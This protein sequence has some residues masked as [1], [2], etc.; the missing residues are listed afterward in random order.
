M[1]TKIMSLSKVVL[2]EVLVLALLLSHAGTFTA[3]ETQKLLKDTPFEEVVAKAKA[4]DADAQFYLAKGHASS[5]TGVP[6]N[7]QESHK[8]YIAAA[9]NN[10][11]EA[12]FY[13]GRHYY[14]E[15]KSTRGNASKDKAKR[16]QVAPIALNWLNKAANQS[17]FPAWV[18][19]G[20]AFEDGTVFAKDPVE[21]YKWY[22]LA[23]EKGN[24]SIIAPVTQRN[25][26]SLKLTPAQIE[27]AKR[28]ALDFWET[29]G[30]EKKPAAPK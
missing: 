16:Q 20:K 4:G 9:T 12:Q 11:P 24:A 18:F 22:H 17:C 8:W 13:L 27:M 10:V 15:A 29:L 7:P 23:I 14:E 28:R 5:L 19:L 30:E 26:L 25:A 1:S 2:L 21:A 3:A 6:Y